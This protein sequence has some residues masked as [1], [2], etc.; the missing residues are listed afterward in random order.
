MTFEL[1]EAVRPSKAYLST[2][3]KQA[4]LH[5]SS[6]GHV[7]GYRAPKLVKGELIGVVMVQWVNSGISVPMRWD[8]LERV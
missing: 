3:R 8:Q 5:G 6:I 1:G 4:W 7:T 2:P